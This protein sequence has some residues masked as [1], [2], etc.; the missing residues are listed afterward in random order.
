MEQMISKISDSLNFILKKL[1]MI[2]VQQKETLVQLKD[3]L[4]GL[5]DIAGIESCWCRKCAESISCID[6]HDKGR[7]HEESMCAN[8][9]S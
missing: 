3:A 2:N 4:Y 6:I 9:A 8:C 7:P 5:Q 1:V